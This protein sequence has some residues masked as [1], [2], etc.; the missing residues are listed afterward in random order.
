MSRQNLIISVLGVLLLGVFVLFFVVA[1]GEGGDDVVDEAPVDAPEEES[2]APAPRRDSGRRGRPRV[3]ADVVEGGLAE[4]LGQVVEAETKRK[5]RGITAELM[6]SQ[7]LGFETTSVRTGER[8]RFLLTGLRPTSRAFLSLRAAGFGTRVVGPFAL[9]AGDRRDLGVIALGRGGPIQGRVLDDAGRG[10]ADAEIIL[11]PIAPP[12]SLGELLSN[13]GQMFADLPAVAQTTSGADGEYGI[14]GVPS[15]TYH[16]TVRADGFGDLHRTDIWVNAQGV[17]T[18]QDFVLSPEAVL[19]GRVVGESEQGLPGVKVCVFPNISGRDLSIIVQRSVVTTDDDGRFRLEGIE[20]GRKDL[21]V[22]T[23]PHQFRHIDGVSAPQESLEIRLGGAR[24]IEGRVTRGEDGQAVA[25]VKLLI[26]GNKQYVSAVTDEDGRYRAGPV[27]GSKWN[28]SMDVPGWVIPEDSAE[29]E[30]DNEDVVVHDVELTRGATLSGRVFDRTSLAPI[31]GAEITASRHYGLGNGVS[32]GISDRDGTFRLEGVPLEG[33]RVFARADGY[34]FDVEDQKKQQ[35]MRKLDPGEHV[36]D[37][38]IALDSLLR[39][40]GRV[41]NPDGDPVVGARV[42][43]SRQSEFQAMMFGGTSQN[44]VTD[45]DGRYEVGAIDLRSEPVRVRVTHPDYA[46]AA[47]ILPRPVAS[48]PE[49]ELDILMMQGA[50]VSGTIRDIRDEPLAGLA[51]R[52]SV[53]DGAFPADRRLIDVDHLVDVLQAA[54]LLVCAGIRLGTVQAACHR[55]VQD[56][57]DQRAL[58][59]ARNTGDAVQHAQW[60]PDGLSLQVVLARL[61]H[62]DRLAVAFAARLS[63]RR[64][65]DG[66]TGRPRSATAGSVRSRAAFPAATT[67]PPSSPAPGP[68]STT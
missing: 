10:V 47:K 61:D 54:N 37:I 30:A 56:V 57:V 6:M 26:A 19:A 66:R 60:E 8:G 25:G 28:L 11:R 15:G 46:A 7:D 17:L 68:R 33:V 3:E 64:S 36:A 34:G 55:P 40:R 48:E 67:S 58:S 21:L 31:A 16:V 50:L 12:R 22:T 2:A 53:S 38:E 52:A 41:T 65:C 39:I 29:I 43:T 44:A 18:R 20:R 32:R 42:T 35:K 4:V 45:P 49:H 5:V 59:R 9:F 1:S 62:R 63:A 24:V 13:L 23:G 27:D 51:V 14:Q